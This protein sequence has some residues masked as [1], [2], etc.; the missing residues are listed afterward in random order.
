MI[1]LIG[2]DPRA[3]EPHRLHRDGRSYVETNC[4][5]D[6]IIE[7]VHALGHEPAAALGGTIAVDWEGDQWTFFKPPP[8]DLESLYGIDIHEMQPYRPLEEQIADQLAAGRSM[9]VE[10]D[11]FFL[12]DVAATA[13][14]R[15]HVKSSAA[16]ESIDREAEKLRYFHNATFCELEGEDYRG[17]FAAVS[18]PALPPYVELVRLDRMRRTTGDELREAAASAFRSHLGRV[19]ETNPFRRFAES[20][21]ATLPRLLEGEEAAYHAYA[22]ATVRMAGASFEVAADHVEWLFGGAAAATVETLL[23]LVNGCKMLSFK[24]AR[25]RPFDVGPPVEALA[26]TWERAQHQ[27]AGLQ[28]S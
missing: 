22:F 17:V 5:L 26:E 9:I 13:Y 6:V 8:G 14:R 19:P 25:R 4:Y 15:E 21:E 12:P 23:E 2:T 24:L 3:Y 1:S 27:L 16:I 18:P 7:L 11:S 28:R 20:L 10:L